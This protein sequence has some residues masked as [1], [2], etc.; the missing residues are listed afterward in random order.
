M[1]MLMMTID[2]GA[3]ESTWAE[4]WLDRASPNI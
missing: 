4:M 1:M 2:H 3:D